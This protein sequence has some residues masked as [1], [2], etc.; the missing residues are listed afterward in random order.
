MNKQQFLR[1][2]LSAQ[3][4]VVIVALVLLISG[5]SKTDESVQSGLESTWRAIYDSELEGEPTETVT[6]VFSSDGKMTYNYGIALPEISLDETISVNGTWKAEDGK[7]TIALPNEEDEIEEEY[8]ATYS[9]EGDILKIKFVD[10]DTSEL[11]L[12]K[13]K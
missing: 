11:E 6:L 10:D 13:I 1:C 12:K 8:K 2:N 9:I 3:A 7:L 4:V 5:C